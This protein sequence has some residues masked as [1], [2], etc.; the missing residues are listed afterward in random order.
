[1]LLAMGYSLARAR[2]SIRFSLGIHNTEEEVDFVLKHL[3]EIIAKLRGHLT[4]KKGA[5]VES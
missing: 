3:P 2:G 5:E 4:V 1:V